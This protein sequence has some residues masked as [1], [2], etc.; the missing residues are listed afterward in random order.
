MLI[1]VQSFCDFPKLLI[2]FSSILSTLSTRLLFMP[3][4][5]HP[6]DT[7]HYCSVICIF[8]DQ[9]FHIVNSTQ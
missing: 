2:I 8:F 9:I 7:S 3:F 5:V 1:G 6:L 4:S